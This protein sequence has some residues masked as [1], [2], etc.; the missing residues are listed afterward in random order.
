MSD[1]TAIDDLI[2]AQSAVDD[3]QDAVAAAQVERD[4]L[5]VLARK[6]GVSAA[7]IA[8]YIG[9]NRARVYQILDRAGLTS[10]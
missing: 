8:E 2:Q 6:T 3:A 4:R 1:S 10:P 9:V 5:I 7:D